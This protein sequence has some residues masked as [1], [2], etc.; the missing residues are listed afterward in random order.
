MTSGCKSK[1]SRIVYGIVV[2]AEVC[3]LWATGLFVPA[4]VTPSRCRAGRWRAKLRK[5]IRS[6]KTGHVTYWRYNDKHEAL[7]SDT[8][9]IRTKL[10][11]VQPVHI[12]PV[13]FSCVLLGCCFECSMILTASQSGEAVELI[14]LWFNPAKSPTHT[15]LMGP[16]D[17]FKGVWISGSLHHSLVRTALSSALCNRIPTTIHPRWYMA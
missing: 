2:D 16:G 10:S 7:N 15:Y 13:L 4:S 3:L 9:W 5:P 1:W 12:Q 6:L 11:S 17:S 8:S 14:S